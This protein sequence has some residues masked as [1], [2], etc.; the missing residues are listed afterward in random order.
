MNFRLETIEGRCGRV[1][2]RPYG[3]IDT[4][5]AGELID[6]VVNRTD[7]VTECDIDLS[8]VTFMDSSG[9]K[10]IVVCRESLHRRAAT[11]RIVGVSNPV[12]KLLHLTGIDQLLERDDAIVSAISN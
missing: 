11:L 3:E 9:I 5:C 4:T 10:A 12:A 7:P 1:T 6:A 2:L 8:R